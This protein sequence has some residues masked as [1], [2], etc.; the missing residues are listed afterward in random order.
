VRQACILI[1]GDAVVGCTDRYV[2][3]QMLHSDSVYG[4]RFQSGESYGWLHGHG[5]GCSRKVLNSFNPA[6]RPNW[7]R[8]RSMPF[9]CKWNAVARCSVGRYLKSQR[10]A[11]P[12][13]S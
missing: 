8:M 6:F 2:S 11:E 9:M 1:G 5:Y 3:F 7:H 4:D 12:F 13:A 10:F